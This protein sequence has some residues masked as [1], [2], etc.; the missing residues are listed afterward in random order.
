VLSRPGVEVLPRPRVAALARRSAA[1]ARHAERQATAPRA[2]PRTPG[3]AALARP[4]VATATGPSRVRARHAER[5]GTVRRGA[6]RM[7]RVAA[8]ARPRVAIPPG[9]S[10]ATA[11]AVG[12]PMVAAGRRP[13]GRRVAAVPA[14]AGHRPR[15]RT[16]AVRADPAAPPMAGSGG[17]STRSVVGRTWR[18]AVAVVTGGGRR[19]LRG[20]V[21]ARRLAGTGLGPGRGG[22]RHGG[23]CGLRGSHG[24]CGWDG[25]LCGCGSRSW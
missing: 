10:G 9:P 22:G 15:P 18:R 23:R 16:V 8:L 6:P 14:R 21:P 3:V 13:T 1:P 12:G 25:P 24:R 5:Q 17:R 2:A 7:A 11:P 4:R 20:V 19:M